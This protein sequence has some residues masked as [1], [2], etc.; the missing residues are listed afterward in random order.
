MASLIRAN[1][2]LGISLAG[3]SEI[4]KE[5]E[6]VYKAGIDVGYFPAHAVGRDGLRQADADDPQSA[7]FKQA[8][9]AAAST[10]VLVAAWQI[11]SLF[12]PHYLFP[13]VHRDLL[14]DRG[15]LRRRPLLIE[16]LVT[17]ARIFGGLPARSC[18]A[19]CWP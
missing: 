1:D 14:A 17:A 7:R 15:H 12:F 6:G 13:S 18:S 5:I 2:R 19:A 16:V 3:A 11:A 8:L 10:I 4:R 9:Q